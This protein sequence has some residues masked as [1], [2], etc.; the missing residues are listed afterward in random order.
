MQIN[1]EVKNSKL[2][3]LVID[4]PEGITSETLRGIS[5]KAL[6][7]KNIKKKFIKP[8]ALARLNKAAELIIEN[9]NE[10]E[11]DVLIKHMSLSS[12]AARSYVSELRREGVIEWTS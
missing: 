7:R 8:S 6:L 10:Y 3:W 11:V 4:N 5:I 12:Q 2:V 1:Y 9:A